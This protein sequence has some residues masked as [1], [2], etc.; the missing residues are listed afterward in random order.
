MLRSTQ[1]ITL[2]PTMYY[3]YSSIQIITFLL[4]VHCKYSLDETLLAKE[5]ALADAEYYKQQKVSDA[6]KV[7]K[8]LS[9]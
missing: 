8:P 4:I 5:K 6:N 7:S 3:K 2:L 1:K 9:W